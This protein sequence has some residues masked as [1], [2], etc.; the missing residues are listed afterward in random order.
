MSQLKTSFLLPEKKPRPCLQSAAAH[1]AEAYPAQRAPTQRKGKG[2]EMS[3]RSDFFSF[4]G[5]QFPGGAEVLT[6]R[7]FGAIYI[8]LEAHITL[9]SLQ[10]AA[11]NEPCPHHTSESGQQ[12]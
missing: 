7:T 2:Q 8:Y 9:L 1:P 12:T 3:H 11:I 5:A 6:S 10:S 4:Q